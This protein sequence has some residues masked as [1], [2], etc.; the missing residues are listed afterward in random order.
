MRHAL[1]LAFSVALGWQ[2]GALAQ[3][4]S[5]S[6]PGGAPAS[7]GAAPSAP[8]AT[9]AP[10]A[11]SLVPSPSGPA[12]Q[13][14]TGTDLF[15]PSRVL[16]STSGAPSPSPSTAAPGNATPTSPEGSPSTGLRGSTATD[17]GAATQPGGPTRAAPGVEQPSQAS[18]GRPNPG[19]A[20]SSPQSARTGKNPANQAVADCMQLWDA[21]THMTKGE[22]QRTCRRIQNRLDNISADDVLRRDM[23]E[24]HRANTRRAGRDTG[25]LRQP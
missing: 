14:R 19:G 1:F 11:P 5:P 18:S 16:P 7:P 15:P 25:S 22:W 23:A 4:G 13:N 3:T 12:S 21:G 24:P 8:S 6:S 17:P 20:N 2:G 10:G 9:P